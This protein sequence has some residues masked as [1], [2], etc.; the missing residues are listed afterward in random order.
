MSGVRV[1]HCPPFSGNAPTPDLPLINSPRGQLI[2]NADDFGLTS[3]VN[4]GIIELHSAGLVTSTSLMARAGA[5][6]EAIDLALQT[7]RSAWVATWFWS[8]ANRCSRRIKFPRSS[9][10]HTGHFPHSLNTFLARLFTGRI[11]A[12]EVEA[13]AGAQID[14]LQQ[15]G[16]RLTHIDTH[17]HTHVLPQVLR[18]VLRAARLAEFARSAIHLSRSGQFAPRR[19]RSGCALSR[20]AHCAGWSRS[21]AGSSRKKDL[22]LPDGT[23]AVIG[24]GILDCRHASFPAREPARRHMGAGHTSRL[25]RRRSRVASAR[26]FVLRATSSARRSRPSKNFP[27]IELISFADSQPALALNRK[28]CALTV[29]LAARLTF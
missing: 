10:A 6:D 16:I 23:I 7:P 4:R 14:S 3:G 19:A 17:K 9:I 28:P 24:T 5:T 20:S 21:V 22:R 12:A 29:D 18:P 8:T 1:P 25:Q 2:V 11:R 26:V 27:A 13:E 15:R